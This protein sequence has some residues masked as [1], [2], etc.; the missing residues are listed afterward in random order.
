[1]GRIPRTHPGELGAA[2]LAYYKPLVEKSYDDHPRRIRD[3]EQLVSIMERYEDLEIFLADMALEPP[4][5]TADDH[6]TGNWRDPDRLTLSTVH[7][8]KG[9]EWDAVF[10]LWA[11][12]GRFPSQYAMEKEKELEEELRL[13][14]VAATRARERLFFLCPA[15][16]FD[17][18]TGTVL[19][20]PARF[21]DD[22]PENLLERVYLE[23]E[24]YPSG[25]GGRW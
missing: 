18:A 5:A 4:T 6:L 23:G 12:D 20:R 8:A 24:E 19:N 25:F 1:L 10:V 21:V 11:M 7:S 17:R 2:V 14:Y 15:Y 3:L 22:L 16:A 13:M 9:L